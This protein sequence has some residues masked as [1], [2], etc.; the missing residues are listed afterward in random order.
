MD[1]YITSPDES[2][3]ATRPAVQRI[4]VGA[5][6]A[7]VG[8]ALGSWTGGLFMVIVWAGFRLVAPNGLWRGRG[9]RNLIRV[10]IVSTIALNGALLTLWSPAGAERG[11]ADAEV[12]A[13]F[14]DMPTANIEV[15][16][17]VAGECNDAASVATLGHTHASAFDAMRESYRELSLLSAAD[18]MADL[19][20][21]QQI[22]RFGEGGGV[23]ERLAI[24][25]EER[26][27]GAALV[28]VITAE[29]F[30]PT[31]EGTAGARRALLGSNQ[32]VG[33]DG[34]RV[35]DQ[36]QSVVTIH[37]MGPCP[38][39]LGLDFW[40]NATRDPLSSPWSM[41]EMPIPITTSS[42]HD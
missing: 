17:G 19:D 40:V 6:L 21:G 2:R 25:V 13:L 18:G 34:M 4:W 26:R 20:S 11:G 22:V 27:D 36:P 29:L 35:P 33:A 8:S 10:L 30:P 14:A 39:G 32:R 3:A 5:V 16:T 12:A 1:D 28:A 7:L 23:L 9:W 37:T 41:T 15:S 24:V 42:Y 38:P 31:T